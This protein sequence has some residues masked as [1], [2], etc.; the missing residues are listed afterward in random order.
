MAEVK[1]EVDAQCYSPDQIGADDWL[2]RAFSYQIVEF[3]TS[4]KP[5]F[6]RFLLSQ[7]FDGVIY[8]DPDIEIYSDLDF[9]AHWLA[10]NDSLLTP[11]ILTAYDDDSAFPREE[12]ILRG[13]QFN[14]GF[15]GFR[16]SPDVE[17]FLGWWAKNL[18]EKCLF[19][20]SKRYFV[21]QFWAGFIPSFL[22]SV[23]IIHDNS[24]NVAYWN[25]VQ[26]GF[27]FDGQKAWTSD[28]PLCFFHFS[29]LQ[30]ENLQQVS[31][32]QTRARAPE[33][34]DLYA[35]LTN[36]ARKVRFYRNQSRV[37]HLEYSFSKYA[38]GDVISPENR[39]RYMNMS[40]IQKAS[41]GNPFEKRIEVQSIR[42]CDGYAAPPHQATEASS[43]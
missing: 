12:D 21:D 10:E 8:F 39:I 7:K 31:K 5:C 14:L 33:G 26:R 38:D 36:Y 11:H 32:Y 37:A 3:N 27:R 6:L 41:F 17:R 29:G 40:P 34:S 30:E 25:L 9:L 24:Y 13:G 43:L 15:V 4:L 35:F 22:R 23:K 18:E 28:G 42:K 2:H 1:K 20:P 19:D 16:K